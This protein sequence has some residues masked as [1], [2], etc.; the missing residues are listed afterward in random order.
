M[1]RLFVFE[2]RLGV[3]FHNPRW[4]EMV[5]GIRPRDSDLPRIRDLAYCGDGVLE[6]CART[7]FLRNRFD[8][9]PSMADWKGRAVSDEELSHTA[10]R[11][12]LLEWLPNEP[13]RREK[14]NGT[15][16]EAILACILL[17]RGFNRVERFLVRHHFPYIQVQRRKT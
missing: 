11:M 17:D 14:A 9:N 8:R 1:S 13:H 7:F 5:V 6:L 15:F 10:E 16:M 12:Q 3:K 4:I 2:R